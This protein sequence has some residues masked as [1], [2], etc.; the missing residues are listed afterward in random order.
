M[1]G[2]PKTKRKGKKPATAQAKKTPQDGFT[3]EQ[4]IQMENKMDLK[5]CLLCGDVHP[6]K[7][8]KQGASGWRCLKAAQTGPMAPQSWI[9]RTFDKPLWPYARTYVDELQ[10]ADSLPDRSA[11]DDSS[12]QATL[13]DESEAAAGDSTQNTPIGDA[14]AY[15][16]TDQDK[17]QAQADMQAKLSAMQSEHDMVP[18]EFPRHHGSC[19]AIED[20]TETDMATNFY[21]IDIDDNENTRFHEYKILDLPLGQNNR[22]V[23]KVVDNMIEHVDL[24]RNKSSF[25]TDDMSTI[26]SWKQLHTTVD[27]DGIVATYNVPDG[28]RRDGTPLTRSLRLKHLREIDFAHLRK[29]VS[30][31]MSNPKLWDSSVEVMALNI[32]ISK[33]LKANRVIRLGA[34]KFFIVNKEV[35]LSGS[36]RTMHGYFYT[37]KALGGGILLNVNYDTSAFYTAQSVSGFLNDTTTF[38]DEYQRRSALNA[39]RV[40]INYGRDQTKEDR[41]RD[42]A[43][44]EGREKTIQGTSGFMKLEEL[45]FNKRRDNGN[46]KSWKVLQYLE[47]TKTPAE[48]EVLVKDVFEFLDIADSP[49]S[50][51]EKAIEY[52]AEKLK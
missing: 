44:P 37:I 18:C 36:L 21:K 12:F 1:E 51:A 31:G 38:R 41:D 13:G 20:A 8:G 15:I 6:E 25:A 19:N 29:Y 30:G 10:K 48:S 40:R 17:D 7:D 45:E 46:E 47:D 22:K 27:S 49:G 28:N 11:T 9:G 14:S 26:I 2:V 23:K 35:Y 32:M 4:L 5:E 39:L 16:V 50:S 34:N 52:A 3:V 24:L 33:C 42:L 43:D